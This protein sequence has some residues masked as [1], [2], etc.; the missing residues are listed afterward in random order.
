MRG[1]AVEIDRLADFTAMFTDRNGHFR[2]NAC[3]V[4]HASDDYLISLQALARG[5]HKRST[6]HDTLAAGQSTSFTFAPTTSG[7]FSGSVTVTSNATNSPLAISLSG[8]GA[9]PVNH[10]VTLGWA[11]SSSSFAGFNVYRGLLSGGPYTKVNTALIS[12]TSFIDTGVASG[13]TYYYYAATEVDSTGAESV[14]S[15]EV[16]A[17]IP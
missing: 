10:S 9:A 7:R 12:A 17:T 4:D 14:Y 8:S 2:E 13:Q 11:P 15:S 6:S 5:F 16:I 3:A 1:A